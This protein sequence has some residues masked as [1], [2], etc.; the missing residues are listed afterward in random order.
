MYPSCSRFCSHA[1]RTEG[2]INGILLTTDRLV[3]CY[4]HPYQYQIY[5]DGIGRKL[6]KDLPGESNLYSIRSYYSGE[7]EKKPFYICTND[8]DLLLINNL[9]KKELFSE[10]IVEINRYQLTHNHIP[11]ELYLNEIN[12]HERL[13]DNSKAFKLFERNYPPHIQNND[14]IKLRMSELYI[15]SGRFEQAKSLLNGLLDNESPEIKLKANSYLGVVLIEQKDYATAR[16]CFSQGLNSQR[17]L[18]LLDEY[19][20]VKRKSVN[21]AR[22]LS[23]LPGAGYLYAGYKQS[24]VVSFIMNVLLGYA[25]YSCIK[26]QNYGMAGLCGFLNLSF[27]IGNFKGAGIAVKRHNH[28]Q[29]IKILDSIY[30]ENHLIITN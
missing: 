5:E 13:Y 30:K 3:R 27:Y 26:N 23:I 24:A 29:R 8:I 2:F 12:C 21:V 25:T 11:T 4:T 10:A 14:T 18:S 28:Y 16:N 17:N 19:L 7:K 1:I 22:A 15:S 9:I 6:F 20:N